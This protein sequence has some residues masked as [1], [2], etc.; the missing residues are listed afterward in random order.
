MKYKYTKYTFQN[1]IFFFL[2]DRNLVLCTLDWWTDKKHLKESHWELGCCHFSLFYTPSYSLK[3]FIHSL[4]TCTLEDCGSFRAYANGQWTRGHPGQAVSLSQDQHAWDNHSHLHTHLWELLVNT[5]PH[6]PSFLLW[7]DCN[8][9]Y[10]WCHR[11]QLKIKDLLNVDLTLN[12]CEKRIRKQDYGSDL[13][14]PSGR[15]PDP[16]RPRTP[17][18]DGQLPPRTLPHVASRKQN[19]RHP[20]SSTLIHSCP[21]V[22]AF[23]N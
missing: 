4:T 3:K 2:T 17:T 23:T 14:K 15:G 12:V 1:Y 6:W 9:H 16:D 22:S 19:W 21:N 18:G 8:D 10:T 20:P 5:E 7:G 13:T 11:K